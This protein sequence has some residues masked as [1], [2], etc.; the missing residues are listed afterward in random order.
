MLHFV[1]ENNA[2][3][4]CEAP[5][6]TYFFRPVILEDHVKIRRQATRREDF[7]G[8]SLEEYE[9]KL[10]SGLVSIV[11]QSNQDDLL[12]SKFPGAQGVQLEN[13]CLISRLGAS[14]QHCLTKCYEQIM[15]CCIEFDLMSLFEVHSFRICTNLWSMLFTH[16]H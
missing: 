3:Q 7:T 9:F 8:C 2:I 15:I 1:L 10:E 12:M 16:F 4:G 6:D 11:R 14:F 13:A 5:P